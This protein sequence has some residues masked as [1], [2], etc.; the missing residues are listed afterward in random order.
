[1]GFELGEGKNELKKHVDMALLFIITVRSAASWLEKSR[2]LITIPRSLDIVS[3]RPSRQRQKPSIE[4]Y[5]I[6]D[7]KA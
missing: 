2:I 5:L 3:G 6:Q 7:V 1:M 4:V